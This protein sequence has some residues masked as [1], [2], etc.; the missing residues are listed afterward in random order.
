MTAPTVRRIDEIVIPGRRLGRH[1]NHDPRSLAYLVQPDGA[2]A[3][4]TWTRDIP[5]LD[6]GDI[7]SCTGNAATGLLG[8]DPCYGSLA[9]QVHAGLKLDES[10]AL[11][12]Y[13]AAETI[14]GDGPYPPN[15]N[16]SS[17]LS[18]AKAA[19]NAGLISG[20]LHMTSVAACQTAIQQG[21][22]MVGS[23][24]Y[25]G[26][27]TPDANGLVTATGTIRG[28]HEYECHEYDAAN[29][30]WWFWNS[31]GVSF[32]VGGRF[33]YSSATLAQLL[34]AQGDATQ[35]VPISQPAPTPTPVPTP[36]G[37]T[38]PVSAPV[39]AHIHTAAVRAKMTDAAWVEHH[40][41]TYFAI[42]P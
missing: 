3:S 37:A 30:L 16:G 19:K 25:T 15:D 17:G 7:G 41:D 39:A 36:Q 31:W 11:K 18:V 8:T 2:V 35:L 1:V 28:G 9:T 33:C 26:M 27:D 22:F 21:P 14:D 20:Y 42:T 24:W 29:D 40:F 23:D 12:L 5:V 10:E 32:G 4:R 13:S 6:Q 34:A 38:F